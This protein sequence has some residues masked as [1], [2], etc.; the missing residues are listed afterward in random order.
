V[1]TAFVETVREKIKKGNYR[2]VVIKRG[3]EIICILRPSRKALKK[4]PNA[5]II[6][7]P[8]CCQEIGWYNVKTAEIK[9][10][11]EITIYV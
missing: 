3:N 8:E 5:T 2:L 1:E 4:Y 6:D 9:R 7:L 11:G 10:E